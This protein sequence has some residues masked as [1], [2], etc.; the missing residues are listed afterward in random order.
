MDVPVSAFRAELKS[1][2]ERAKDGEPIIITDRGIPVARLS[3]IDATDLVTELVRDGHLTAP[4]SP[5]GT[6]PEPVSPEAADSR[7]GIFGRRRR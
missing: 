1:W 7:G 5:R 2:I 6:L 4:E 3:G